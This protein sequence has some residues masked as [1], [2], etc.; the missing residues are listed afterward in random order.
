MRITLLMCLYSQ[1]HPPGDARQYDTTRR[2]DATAGR[3]YHLPVMRHWR[4]IGVTVAVAAV[5]VLLLGGLLEFLAPDLS[6]QIRDRAAELLSGNRGR[7]YRIALGAQTGSSFRVGTVLNEYLRRKSGYELELLVN[8]APGNLGALVD[9]KEQI[10]FATINSAD[11]EAVKTEGVYGVAALETQYFFVVVPNESPVR[12]FRELA[13]AVNPGAREAND[14]PTLGERLLDYYGLLPAASPSNASKPS[15]ITIVRP[16]QGIV[17]DLESGHNTAT[18]RT[19]FLHA[20]LM[21]DTLRSGHF[22]LVPLRDHEALAKSIPGTKAGVIPPGLYGPERRI[23]DE[24]V[25]TV[26]VTLLLVARENIPGRVVRDILEALYDPRFARDLQLDLSEVSGRNL[27]GVPLHRAA[28]VFYH[29]NDLPTSDRLGRVSFVVSV[30]AGLVATIEFVSRFRR[31]DRIARRRRL[32]ESELARLQAIRRGA[33][34]S[35]DPAVATALTR[36]ADDLLC[37][38][39]QDAA[40]GLLDT[41]GIQSLRSLHEVCLRSLQPDRIRSTESG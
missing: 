35:A 21:D 8:A 32:L 6:Y 18:T 19:Q 10:D 39:E 15:R 30:I 3:C 23:P 26:A 12:E 27:G 7:K 28:E 36:Q 13:G 2:L 9:P 22:R 1:A 37:N 17:A 20:G 40:A 11:D 34:E 29:R 33:E 5:G 38:A 25:P 16:Q 4:S 41:A 31:N 14:P 24:P